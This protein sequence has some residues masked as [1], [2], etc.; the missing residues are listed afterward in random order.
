M[1]QAILLMS[2]PEQLASTLPTFFDKLISALSRLVDTF[3]QYEAI[4]DIFDGE[5]P[6]RIRQHLERVYHDFFEFL[7]IAARVFTASSGRKSKT[8]IPCLVETDL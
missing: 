7:R 4:V 2:V 5:P 8:L 6:S 3:P 1:T